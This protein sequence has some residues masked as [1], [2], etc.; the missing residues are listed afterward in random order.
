[1]L[2]EH[3]YFAVM[4]SLWKDE[5][6][7]AAFLP[8]MLRSVTNPTGSTLLKICKPLVRMYFQSKLVRDLNGQVCFTGLVLMCTSFK[9]IFCRSGG[10][11]ASK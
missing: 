5:K 9:F 11:E 2:E 10:A 7:S 3:T 1:M 6:V 8:E 4:C